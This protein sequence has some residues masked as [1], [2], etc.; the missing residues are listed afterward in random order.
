MPGKAKNKERK[1]RE[2]KKG[3]GVW[4][5]LGDRKTRQM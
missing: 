3:K 5:N 2:G 1:I 4:W